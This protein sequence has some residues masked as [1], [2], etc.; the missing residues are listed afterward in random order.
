MPTP[1]IDPMAYEAAYA[2]IQQAKIDRINADLVL[3]AII[4]VI[5]FFVWMFR[6]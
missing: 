2:A 5:W 1:T 6:E 3:L 4:G